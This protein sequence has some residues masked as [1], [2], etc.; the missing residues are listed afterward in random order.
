M[1]DIS[2]Q[3]SPTLIDY[4]YKVEAASRSPCIVVEINLPTP[5]VWLVIY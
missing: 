5:K 3:V 2:S 4:E 1:A